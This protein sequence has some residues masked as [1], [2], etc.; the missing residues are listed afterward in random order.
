MAFTL[1]RLTLAKN[2]EQWART[3]SETCDTV[4]FV[5]V[6]AFLLIRPFVAQAFYIPSESMERTLLVRDRLIVNKFGY[7]VS[8]PQRGDVVVF[9]APPQATGGQEG[10]DFIKR[11]IGMPGDTI[12][13]TAAKLTI[14]GTEIDPHV[15]AAN[16]H[17]Y[18]RNRLGLKEEDAIKITPD[19]L[20]VNGTETISKERVAELL[21]Q[22]GAKVTLTPGKTYLNGKVQDEPYTREDPN[23]DFPVDGSA[24]QIPSG[25]YFMMGDNRNR[26][27]DSHMWGPLD[28]HRVVG[29]AVF[30]FWPPSRISVIH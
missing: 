18:L 21:G 3:I 27:A 10:V 13:V 30:V 2:K 24:L 28:K 29:R 23:Y 22:P 4:N 16:L 26:S 7:R 15:E 25:N 14:N 9:E 20:R 1:V 17:D 6:L 19:G 5:L 12:R 8:P 11:L